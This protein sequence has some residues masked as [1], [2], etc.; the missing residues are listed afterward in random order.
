MTLLLL[1][2]DNVSRQGCPTKEEFLLLRRFERKR[3]SNMEK[4]HEPARE[5]VSHNILSCRSP[6]FLA[7]SQQ[8]QSHFE[9][10]LLAEGKKR[11][12]KGSG[13]LDS[14]MNESAFCTFFCLQRRLLEIASLR[15]ECLGC[16]YSMCNTCRLKQELV[17]ISKMDQ[18]TVCSLS[19]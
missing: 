5:A 2:I 9:I 12:R 3:L 19:L 10:L 13:G 8:V 18:S 11:R 14:M 1:G 7:S 15:C 6:L 16:S 17:K 4:G